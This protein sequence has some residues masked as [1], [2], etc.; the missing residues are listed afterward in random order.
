MSLVL[1]ANEMILAIEEELVERSTIEGTSEDYSEDDA[2]FSDQDKSY[3]IESAITL[4]CLNCRGVILHFLKF[5]TSH[6]I[7]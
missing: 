1:E 2:K 4:L 3:D 6:S 7:L 5:F